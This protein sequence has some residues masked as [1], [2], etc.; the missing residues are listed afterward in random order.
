MARRL[1]IVAV[2]GSERVGNTVEV[3]RY[4]ADLAALR[5]VDFESI[6]LRDIRM[7]ACGPC[8]DC[9]TRT[10]PCAIEDDVADVVARLAEADG[11]ILAA[12]V[13]GF[14]TSALMQTFIERAGIGFLRFERP[15]ENKVGGVIVLA[16]RYA[17]ADVSAHLL[18]NLLL[19]RMIVVGA[20]FPAEVRGLHVGEAVHDEEGMTHLTYMMD[21]MI[22]MMFLLEQHRAADGTLPELAMEAVNERVGVPQLEN[23]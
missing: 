20:G 18:H 15:L 1:R 5:G 6:A 16:R 9:Y 7:S 21:R 12:P 19:N 3:L 2:N 8:G 14:G 13:Y 11:V 17:G 23:L 22:S 10:S 4:A